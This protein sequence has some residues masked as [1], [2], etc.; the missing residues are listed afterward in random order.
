MSFGVSSLGTAVSNTSSPIAGSQLLLR[1]SNKPD[2]EYA[3]TKYAPGQD[4]GQISLASYKQDTVLAKGTFYTFL[5]KD[6]K[7][8]SAA[9]RVKGVFNLMAK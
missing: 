7:A 9:Y 4:F 8:G 1:S 2:V 6:A 3:L 5:A